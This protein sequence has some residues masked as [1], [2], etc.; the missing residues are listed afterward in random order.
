MDIAKFSQSYKHPTLCT[1][2]VDGLPPKAGSSPSSASNPDNHHWRLRSTDPR[3]EGK[4][5][6]RLHTI[7]LYFWTVY[8]AQ[9]FVEAMRKCLRQE[10]QNI[11]TP[12]SPEPHAEVMSPVVRQLENIAITDPAYHNGQTRNSR[13]L[14]MPPVSPAP[15]RQHDEGLPKSDAAIFTP[16]AYNPAAPPAPEVIKHREKTPPPPEAAGG[17]GLAA[18]A[19]HDQVQTGRPQAF[20][21]YGSPPMGSASAQ[22]PYPGSTQGHG[23]PAYGSTS[24]SSGYTSPQPNSSHGNRASSVSSVPLPPP[25]P[26]SA[27][28]N[29]NPYFPQSSIPSF[30][31]PPHGSSSIPSPHSQAASPPYAPTP[32]NPNAHFLPSGTTPMESPATQILGDSYVGGPQQPLQHLQPQY[33]DYLSSRP[34]QPVGGYS[35]YKYDQQPSRHSHGHNEDYG[36]HSQVYRPTEEESQGHGKHRLSNAPA[37]EQVGKLEARAERA[38][39]GVNRLLRKLEKKIG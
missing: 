21:P 25:P 24:A 39:K 7:D 22:Q 5:L 6:F 30:A 34:Q 23:P 15:H 8:D 28:G 2:V 18:A 13:N 29:G 32:P 16:L 20:S 31:P 33:A 1:I 14:S 9:T 35:D 4:F 19:Y 3:D 11:D 10:Q 26:K 36:I 27:G 37:G 12:I 17:T 38:E